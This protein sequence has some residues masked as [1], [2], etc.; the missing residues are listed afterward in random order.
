MIEA[1]NN[2]NQFSNNQFS[3]EKTDAVLTPITDPS[4]ITSERDLL[5]GDETHGQ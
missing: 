4:Q 2:P 3:Y 1:I 5:K